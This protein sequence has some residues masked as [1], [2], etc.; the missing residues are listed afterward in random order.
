MSVEFRAREALHEAL[1]RISKSNDSH[2]VEQA[3]VD[4]LIGVMHAMLCKHE[5]ESKPMGGDPAEDAS[6]ERVTLCKHCG[7]EL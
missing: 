5:F 3:T 4:G 7:L 6:T 2:Y 1:E